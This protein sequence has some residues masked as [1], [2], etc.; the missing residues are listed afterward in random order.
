MR[1]LRIVVAGYF[2][3]CP[4]GGYAWQVAHYLLGLQRLGHDV[5][6][7]EDNGY[8]APAFDPERRAFEPVYDYG[9]KAAAEFFAKI[10]FGDR[11]SFTD[12][13]RGHTYGAQ[14]GAV[15]QRVADADV[16][17]NLGGVNRVDPAQRG[18]R[19][20]LY[21]DLDPAYTQL[22]LV[23]GDAKL[24]ALLAEQTCLF[25]T[26][27]NIGTERSPIP[28][29]GFS[30]HPTRQPV[31]IDQWA[32]RRAAGNTYTTIG[33]WNIG[34]RDV[35]FQGETFHWRKRTE[36]LRCLELPRL[37]AAEFELAMDVDSV[38]GDVE[39]LQAHG[40]RVTDPLS[41]STDPWKYRDYIR[42]SRGEFTVAKDM[43]IRLRS[44]WFSDRAAC[45][46]AAGR[47]VVEQDTAFGDVL[48]LGPGL[49]AFRTV[50]EAA[51]A[52]RIIEADHGRAGAHAREVA[53]EYFAAEKVLGALLRTSGL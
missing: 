39:Q 6:F 30:W 13:D 28:T 36:F 47:P 48:P 19:A 14:P 40:W 16:L 7:Y 49:H 35:Q 42:G 20:C 25:T 27:E 33:K 43:N 18:G 51:A 50:D 1:A 10:G 34:G 2:V 11:W 52:I 38:P 44:G 24:R 3:R 17:I 26:G 37:S 29:G 45:Y 15:P 53:H 5:W 22:R 4:L 21:I 41:V 8:H 9:V 32:C 31:V 23:D 12:V 46:L